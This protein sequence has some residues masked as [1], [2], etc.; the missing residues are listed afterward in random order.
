MNP[1]A[2]ADSR[3]TGARYEEIAR[4]HL[5]TAGLAVIARNFSC[6]HGEIDLVMRDRD[7]VV[8]V[9]VRYRRGRTNQGFGDGVDSVGAAKRA[10]LIRAAGMFLSQHPRLATR[11]C[12][13]DVVAI[14]GDAAEPILDWL[15]NAF[16]TT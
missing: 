5:E 4:S 1:H 16:E 13:F 9:E 10:K 8:F 14:A 6:R 7:T 3:S 12:R 2:A 11:P 15:P